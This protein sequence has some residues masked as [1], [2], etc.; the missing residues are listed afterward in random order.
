MADVQVKIQLQNTTPDIINNFETTTLT[1]NASSSD[2]VSELSTKDNGI[3]MKSW[4]TPHIVN[5][6]TILGL[7][8]KDGIV[9][10]AETKLVGQNGYSGYVFGAVS[11]TNEL[12]VDIFVMGENID[13]IIIY[14]DKNANQFPTRAYL[15]NDTKNVIYSDDSVWAIRFDAPANSQRITFTH[16]NRANYNACITAVYRIDNTLIFNKSDLQS[17][18]SISQSTGQ[19][20]EVYY[21]VTNSSGSLEIVDR[22][23][24]LKD[25]IQDGVIDEDE[26]EIALVVN[27]KTLQ[28]QFCEN[29][30]YNIDAQ[31]LSI[32][33]TSSKEQSKIS[34]L[35]DKTLIN[36]N[37][38]DY[39]SV[40]GI[41]LKQ[42]LKD[43]V[44]G[45]QDIDDMLQEKTYMYGN[46]QPITIDEYLQKIKTNY[47][48]LID[49]TNKDLIDAIC[50]VAQVHFIQ[51]TDGKYKFISAR[52]LNSYYQPIKIK[53][54]QMFSSLSSDIVVRNKYDKVVINQ[55][56]ISKTA[57]LVYEKEFTIREEGLSE[58]T[59]K[60]LGLDSVILNPKSPWIDSKPYLQYSEAIKYSKDFLFI[61]PDNSIVQ[62]DIVSL[63]RTGEGSTH[64][65][66]FEYLLSFDET[67][68]EKVYH[69][70]NDAQ[71]NH[72][73]NE[74]YIF[75][76]SID[77][78]PYHSDE[79]GIDYWA[80]SIK[81]SIVN[82]VVYK[83]VTQE[84]SYG[85]GS[86]VVNI[87]DNLLLHNNTWLD[88]DGT[89]EPMTKV[90]AENI[91]H[92]Y[93][94]GIRTATAKVGCLDYYYQDGTLAKKWEKG[95]ILD[96]GD[97]VSFEGERGNWAI[98][99]RKFT[100]EGVPMLNLELREVKDI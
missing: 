46:N 24:E 13:S 91:L 58:Y 5:K 78:Y 60:Y 39:T 81:I 40:G 52:P 31:T 26:L 33:L 43:E 51:T 90:V 82:A 17:V 11:N 50:N 2:I 8:L 22:Y 66:H 59:T 61:I 89:K 44:F 20:K 88:N 96:V 30:E 84:I 97:I 72:D 38:R 28:K 7:G 53:R 47:F 57:D 14:G 65:R 83:P 32:E 98:T 48:Y 21:G 3:N 49:Y 93:K 64:T 6:E 70:L 9:G 77:L 16:W 15:N 19:P 12:V 4:A 29:V 37:M 85:I 34:G 100:Y 25:Y 94:R 63:N 99:G 87:Q 86:N 10:G 45:G 55:T 35:L 36:K 76:F 27:G 18:E 69:F 1:N 56:D 71:S 79:I 54:S 68:G 74:P 75:S 62:Y 80:N 92:D 67:S 95:E 23:G 73:N 41:T 42:I